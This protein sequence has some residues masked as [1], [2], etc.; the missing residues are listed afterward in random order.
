MR[1]VAQGQREKSVL[2]ASELFSP[3]ASYTTIKILLA[4]TGVRNLQMR[5]IDIKTAFL[6]SKRHKLTYL[7]LPQGHP[8]KHYKNNVW[9][10][11]SSIYGLRD[12]PRNWN[13]CLHRV[14]V[15]YGLKSFELEPCLYKGNDLWV[16]IYVDD[17]LYLSTSSTALDEFETYIKKGFNLKLT[18]DVTKYIGY[19]V[20][21]SSKRLKLHAGEYIHH[22]AEKF[23]LLNA[24]AKPQPVHHAHRLDEPSSPKLGDK[25][26]YQSLLGGL[27]YINNLCRPDIS[28]ITNFLARRAHEPTAHTFRLAKNV[29][30]YL[31]ATRFEGLCFTRN[32]GILNLVAY[33]D[34]DWG[35]EIADR[36]SITG[37]VIMIDDGV[38]T[39]KTKKQDCVAKSSF[40][41]DFIALSECVYNVL[42]AKDILNFLN[43]RIKMPI[44]VYCDNQTTIHAF[45]SKECTNK[46]KYIDIRYHR[47]KNRASKKLIG[48]TYIP[49]E[50]NVA[51]LLTKPVKPHI[52]KSLNS[53][54]VRA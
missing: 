17:I 18:T 50:K 20:E 9:V 4:L 33:S 44:P 39:Y 43:V 10:S 45:K 51:D 49:T 34:S 26:K 12:S 35:S 13:K 53:K 54:L 2:E 15:K 42:L 6:Y 52:F 31:R 19:E 1:I 46:S 21:R 24:K 29:L 36:K 16:L 47:V 11:K 48:L 40:E 3:V 32:D 5:Q 30:I 8:D 14:L 23:E 28:Y 41:A 7:E 37:Y 27:S 38:V 25:R 22:L